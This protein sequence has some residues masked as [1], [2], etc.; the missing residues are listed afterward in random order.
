MK[1]LLKLC[2]LALLSLNLYADNGPCGAGQRAWA[3]QRETPTTQVECHGEHH[4]EGRT[5]IPRQQ[6]ADR[7]GEKIFLTQP[8]EEEQERAL[9][10]LDRLDGKELATHREIFGPRKLPSH[11]PIL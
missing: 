9:I 6:H 2:A 4:M 3:S 10:C 1:A 5:P 7:V 11:Q 8:L